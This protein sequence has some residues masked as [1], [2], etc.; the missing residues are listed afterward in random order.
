M[1]TLNFLFC[2]IIAACIYVF[3]LS[4]IGWFGPYLMAVTAAVPPLLVLLSL[5]SMLGMRVGLKAQAQCTKGGEAKLHICFATRRALPLS[6]VTVRL[7]IE[8]LYTGE[9][10]RQRLT[11]K[12]ISN[13]EAVLPLPTDLC[14]TLECRAVSFECRDLL[15]LFAMRHEGG[16]SAKCTV[17]PRASKPDNSLD[18]DAAMNSAAALKPKYGG[19]YSEEHELREY[20][21]GDTVN[22]IHWKLSSKTGKTIIREAMVCENDRVFLLLSDF[23]ADGR[24]LEILSW[25][26]LELSKKEIAHTIVS[27][28]QFEVFNE[29]NTVEALHALLSRPM[30]APCAFDRSAARCIFIISGGEVR[31]Q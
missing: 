30:S 22:S 21:P 13:G 2:L 16:E 28:G 1:P 18:L 6:R 11:Y 31:V 20:R 5:P 4:Y 17:L 15:G 19:G 25:L 29:A 27:G 24:G 12:S 9:I 14:G 8:N 26:S 7:E 23:G 3:R 10:I